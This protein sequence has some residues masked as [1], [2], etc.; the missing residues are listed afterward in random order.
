IL[1]TSWIYGMRGRNFL[2]TV[3]RLARERRELRV[4]DDQIGAPTWCRDVASATARGAGELAA[5]ST[6]GLYHLAARGATSWCGFAGEILKLRGIDT[7]VKPIPT[8]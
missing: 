1:R 2:L 6:G 4:V 3:L 5:G 8:K 7:P